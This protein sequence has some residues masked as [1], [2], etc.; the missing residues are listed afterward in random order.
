MT[1]IT[2]CY[3]GCERKEQC[4]RW[5]APKGEWQ[6]YCDFVP[7]KDGKCSGFWGKDEE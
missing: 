3:Y 4:Y 7:D 6:S 5:T 2:K 1:D